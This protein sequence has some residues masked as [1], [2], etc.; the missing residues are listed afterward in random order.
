MNL[1]TER[2]SNHRAQFTIEIEADQLEAAKRKAARKISRQ[3]GIKGFRKGKAPYGMVVRHVGEGAVLEEALD[4]LGDK[5]YKQAL[6]ESEVKP[7]GPGAFEDFKPEPSPTFVFSA[8][9]PPEVDL[10]DYLDVRLEFEAP[11]ITEDHVDE[12]LRQMRLRLVEVVDEDVA[13]T[14]LGHRV[15]IDVDS[16][17]VDGDPPDEIAEAPLDD[18]LTAESAADSETD[19]AEDA[20][21][22]PKKGDSFA[23]EENT[24]IILDPNEDPFIHGFVENLIDVE[25]GSDVVFELTI[26]DDDAEES[27][28]G[29]RVW[30]A[31]TI[32]D[33]E[34][35]V[36]PE[37]DDDF[38]RRVCRENGDE[39]LDLA[40]LR[41][42]MHDD[43]LRAAQ[44]DARSEFSAMVLDTIV[45]GA[46]IAYPDEVVDEYID[47]LIG[48]FEEGLRQR[49]VAL[50]DFLRL[51]ETSIEDMRERRRERATEAARRNL[52]M[53]EL[54]RAQEIKIS[55]DDL[56]ARLENIMAGYGGSAD[57][58]KLFDTP[59]MRD[60]FRNELVINHINAHL[61]AIGQGEDPAAAIDELRE[62]M[63]AD[64]H[65]ARERLERRNRYQEEDD[66]ASESAAADGEAEDASANQAESDAP[67]LNE[68]SEAPDEAGFEAGNP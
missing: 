68:A 5:L 22:V 41:Q 19:E 63:R 26:P 28:S 42:S 11:T 12:A 29:R 13:V 37:L 56:E 1:T 14:A 64:T 62:R 34:A 30:F 17:F 36:I 38:A 6:D 51:T 60:N 18:A 20:P 25:L 8:P 50:D 39:E 48:E 7:Y 54:V 3:V 53:R 9:L 23:V 40:G 15:T 43:L 10:K 45:A 35:I 33:I 24:Q 66:A 55:D 27:I 21:Y 61:V 65:R 59:Q 16:E 4:D 31:V 44:D 52:V 57:F 58:R 67:P 49:G 46:E 32:R 2:I 47:V